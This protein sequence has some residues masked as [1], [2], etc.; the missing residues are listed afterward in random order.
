MNKKAANIYWNNH[1]YINPR[2]GRKNAMRISLTFQS[3]KP[4][5]DL[6]IN[7]NY[8]IQSVIYRNLESEL[9][10]FLHEEG[11]HLGKRRF[12]LFV[13]SR[14]MGKSQFLRE[15]KKIRFFGPIRLLLASPFE[16]FIRGISQIILK[17]GIYFGEEKLQ[18]TKLEV[19]PKIHSDQETVQVMTLSP[20]IAYST[21][22]KPEGGKYTL[23]FTPKEGDY[24]RI[25][26]ENLI[27]K[28]KI[29]YGEETSF[30]PLQIRPVGRF[31]QEVVLYKGT[32]IKGHSGGFILEGDPR[33]IDIALDAGLG[34]KNSMG[35]GFVYPR[36]GE[37]S[38][39][40]EWR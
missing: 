21:L 26:T 5:I 13:F 2:P 35:F 27:R 11:F 16:P 3:E 36:A 6:P 24:I 34:S 37:I 30:N 22:L 32:V 9:A 4:Y 19:I 33:L 14:L 1:P 39:I 38:S 31:K 15:S 20:V 8:L 17:E 29:I 7:Y 18:I 28:G 40:H 23:Y 25:L 12:T 10:T